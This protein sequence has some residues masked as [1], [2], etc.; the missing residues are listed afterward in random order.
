MRINLMLALVACG[1]ALTGCASKQVKLTE[2]REAPKDR[3]FAFD[4][5]GKETGRITFIRDK[6]FVGGG[7]YIDVVVD[8]AKVATLDPGERATLDI[9]VGRH[10]VYGKG[11]GRGLCGAGGDDKREVRAA[12]M[13]VEKGDERVMRVAVDANGVISVNPQID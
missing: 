9:S 2:A 7:C 3:V 1:L 10:T 8:K 5:S 13:F 12:D 4:T 6:G 11:A